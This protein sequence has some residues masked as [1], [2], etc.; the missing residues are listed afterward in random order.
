MTDVNHL[1]LTEDIVHAIL[2]NPKVTYEDC[3]A[4][5]F[6]LCNC[7]EFGCADPLVDEVIAKQREI[8]MAGQ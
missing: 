3:D 4:L 2:R 5:Y 8:V 6:S 1:Q 7:P